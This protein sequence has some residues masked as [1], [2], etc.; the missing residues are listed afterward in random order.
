MATILSPTLSAPQ[1]RAARALIGAK[2]DELAAWAG[3]AKG[4]VAG[5]EMGK[6]STN[7]AILTALRTALEANGVR[8]MDAGPAHGAGV[9]L[10]GE[11]SALGT[12]PSDGG[13]PLP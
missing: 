6:R 10:A 3:V 5:F 11:G 1:C 4:T 12:D 9:Y 2:Q 7:K 13:G 8:F